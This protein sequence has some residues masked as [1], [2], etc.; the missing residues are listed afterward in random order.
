METVAGNHGVSRIERIEFCNRMIGV[1]KQAQAAFTEKYDPYWWA[2][3]HD[4]A[5]C[6]AEIDAL[7]EDGGRTSCAALNR[8]L[9]T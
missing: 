8:T 7:S 4:I 9:V 6:V 2:L 5:V 1:Y 3:E